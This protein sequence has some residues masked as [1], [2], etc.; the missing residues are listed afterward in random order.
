MDIVWFKI[1]D[2]RV[3]DHEPLY[4]AN[5]TNK[6]LIHIFIWDC[7][8]DDKTSNDIQNMGKL[9]KKFLKESLFSLSKNLKE[10]GIQL[11]IFFGKPEKILSELI[12][13]PILTF[14]EFKSII[15]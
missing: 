8:W 14:K 5:Q 3:R 7:R 9:K 2:L 10:L 1:S 12:C 4:N 6:N 13:C 11:N 15:L